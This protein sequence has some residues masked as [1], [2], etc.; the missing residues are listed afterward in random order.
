MQLTP[1]LCRPSSLQRMPVFIFANASKSKESSGD[2]TESNLSISPEQFNISV[3]DLSLS[4]RTLNC[5]KRT[6][7]NKIGDVIEYSEE[8]LLKIRNFGLKSFNEL[9][10]RLQELNLVPEKWIKESV[11]TEN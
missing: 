2:S 11:Q 4:A 10:D 9:Y 8:D 5:L 3:E 7:I 1:C 6:G